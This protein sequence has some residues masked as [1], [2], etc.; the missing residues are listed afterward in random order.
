[1]FIS[2]S[3]S[4]NYF[5]VILIYNTMRTIRKMGIWMDHADAYLIDCTEEPVQVNTLNSQYSHEV[6][7]QALVKGEHL[8]HNKEQHRESEYY[9]KIGAVIKD[10][11]KV[12]LFGPTDAKAELRNTLVADHHFSNVEIEVKNS[13]KMNDHEKLAFAHNYFTGI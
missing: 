4:G 9:K 11:D 1:M 6:K 8:A 12:L 3:S 13:D 7:E 2:R 5:K 10:Y